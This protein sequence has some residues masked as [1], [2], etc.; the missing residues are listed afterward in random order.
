MPDADDVSEW[1][2]RLAASDRTAYAEVFEAF[3]EPL[4]RYVCSITNDAAAARDVT[5]DVFVRLWDVR[6]GLDPSRSLK[7][8]LYR[9]ARNRAYNHQRDRNTEQ[10]KADDVRH[11]SNARPAA[12]TPPDETVEGEHLEASMREWISALPERQREAIVLS[13][14]EGL[15][16]EQI[17]EVMDISP[18]TVNNHIVR[19]LKR[20]RDRV[21]DYKPALLSRDE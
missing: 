10:E 15:S 18:R 19:G 14:F 5:Q 2:R 20:L 1:C 9:I 16:H 6:D 17:A 4:Y 3:Y 12:P 13:R 8:Y 21:H 11:H 7:A